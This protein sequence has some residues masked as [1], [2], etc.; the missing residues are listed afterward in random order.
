MNEVHTLKSQKSWCVAECMLQCVL[1]CVAVC[2]SVLQMLQHT[3][4]DERGQQ[5]GGPEELVHYRVF[6]LVCCRVAVCCSVLQCVA[7]C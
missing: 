1:Q 6:F 4:M 5:L 3:V 7:V 2:C